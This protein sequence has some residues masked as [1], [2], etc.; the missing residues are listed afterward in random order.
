MRKAGKAATRGS[1]SEMTQHPQNGHSGAG[2]SHQSSAGAIINVDVTPG[3]PLTTRGLSVVLPA[4]NE[5]AVIEKTAR[6]VVE[7][8]RALAPD[9]EVIIVD[10][11]SQDRTGEIADRLAAANP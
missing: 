9:Y 2:Q 10:D 3:K 8:L 5:E 11:G 6:E 4:W 7:T 1:E